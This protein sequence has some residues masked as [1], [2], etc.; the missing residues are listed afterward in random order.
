MPLPEGGHVAKGQP[1]TTGYACMATIAVRPETMTSKSAASL[2]ICMILNKSSN[3]GAWDVK[4]RKTEGHLT[5]NGRAGPECNGR[6]GDKQMDRSSPQE[7]H[8]VSPKAILGLH[9]NSNVDELRSISQ[10]AELRRNKQQYP[11]NYHLL[12]E[13]G[14]DMN[15]LPT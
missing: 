1:V 10:K 4:E 14:H 2:W 7:S 12:V 9:D 6:I 15:V 11:P 13:S 3:R 5:I 8:R